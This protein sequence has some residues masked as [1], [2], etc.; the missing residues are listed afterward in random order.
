MGFIDIEYEI[1]KRYIAGLRRI[2]EFDEEFM[3]NDSDNKTRVII[4]PDFPE[5]DNS[6]KTPHIVV[7]GIAYQTETEST[8]G[9]NFFRDVALSGIRNYATEHTFQIPYSVSLVCMGEGDISR[10]LAN[11]LFYYVSFHAYDF[12]SGNCQLNFRNVGKG[13]SG[14]K[15]QYP[16]KIFQTPITVQGMMAI[17]AVKTPFNY[18]VGN[19]PPVDQAGKPFTAV[20]ISVDN[21]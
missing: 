3:Y 6:F 15:E 5:T 16:E 20:N 10:N 4:T 8:F 11:K 12:L 2:F 1:E 19:P 21:Q 18:L 13:P 7:T 9:N 14:P 17:S